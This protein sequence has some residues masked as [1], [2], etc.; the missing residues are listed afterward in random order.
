MPRDIKLV[1]FTLEKRGL[2]EETVT[3]KVFPSRNRREKE[4]RI[5]ESQPFREQTLFHQDKIHHG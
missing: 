4:D 2:I 5:G 3:A 1:L